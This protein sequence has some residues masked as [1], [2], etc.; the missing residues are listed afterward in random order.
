MRDYKITCNKCGKEIFIQN[1]IPTGEA[2]SVEKKW[3]YFSKGKDGEVHRFDL[4]EECYDELISGFKYPVDI[5][6]R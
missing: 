2:L 1:N 4:C 5:K 3:G 6:E